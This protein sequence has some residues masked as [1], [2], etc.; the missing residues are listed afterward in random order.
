MEYNTSPRVKT[1]NRCY[2]GREF[3][4]LLRTMNLTPRLRLLISAVA[5]RER[6]NLPITAADLRRSTRL[7]NSRE[8]PKLLGQLDSEF[9]LVEYRKDTGLIRTREPGDITEFFRPR[10]PPANLRHWS[11]QVAH[12]RYYVL[13]DNTDLTVGGNVTLWTLAG[14]SEDGLIVEGQTKNGLAALTRLSTKTVERSLDLLEQLGFLAPLGAGLWGL[15]PPDARR[16]AC[17]REKAVVV[18]KEDIES[19]KARHRADVA[20]VVEEFDIEH[21]YRAINRALKQAG[22]FPLSD[23]EDTWTSVME[24]ADFSPEDITYVI[25][26]MKR[27]LKG[28]AL[29]KF[30]KDSKKQANSP[31]FFPL[32]RHKIRGYFGVDAARKTAG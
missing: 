4:P 19:I 20:D 30:W 16:S 32:L 17:F 29:S 8:I 9:G 5:Y 1:L 23:A 31:D 14:K 26:G 24:E 18:P 11:E 21:R 27:G 2:P 3:F 7:D 28:S 12:D 13:A 6:K 25:R 22:F 10:K 15:F